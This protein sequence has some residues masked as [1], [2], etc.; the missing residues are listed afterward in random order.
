MCSIIREAVS[1]VIRHAEATAVLVK[2]AY[3]DGRVSLAVSDDGRGIE[4]GDDGRGNGLTSIRTR[5]DALGGVFE[6]GKSDPGTL[7]GVVFS[8]KRG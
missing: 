6:I 7:L 1:N 5:I 4:D 3:R 2:V 8:A